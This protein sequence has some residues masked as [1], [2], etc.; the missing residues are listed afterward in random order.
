MAERAFREG[1]KAERAG[2]HLKAYFLYVQA[3]Q[4]DAKNPVYSG[5]MA[6]LAQSGALQPRTQAIRDPA[7]ETIGAQLEAEGL[8]PDEFLPAAAPPPRL[9]ASPEKRNFTI[10]GG[11]REMFEQ[12]A[13]AY[14]I[15]LLFEPD[16]KE[17]PPFTFA[18]AD[19]G[20]QEALRSL[21]AATD[22]FVVPLSASTALVA[23]DTVPNRTQLTPVA[24]I[25]VPIPERIS[26][27]E[28]Q[29]LSTAV[30][31]T[32]EIRRIS[33]DASRRV[34]YFRDSVSKVFAAREMFAS[35]SRARAQ[36]AVDVEFISVSKTS[37]LAYGL[38]LP[39]SA[40]II[41]F[42]TLSTNTAASIPAG[43]PGFAAIGGGKTL[44]GIGI[45]NSTALATLGRSAS[46]TLLESQ[47][48]AL[49]GQAVT[50]K[51]GDRYPITTATF[52]GVSGAPVAGGGTIPTIN[53]VD[54][55]LGLKV[56]PTVHD[57][58]EVTLDIEA[59]FKSIGAGGAN[60]I[61]AISNQEYQ[62]KVRLKEGEWAVVA[63]LMQLTNTNNLTGIA[64]LSNIPI[65]GN[66]FRSRTRE[67]DRNEILLVLKPRLIGA[68]AWDEVVAKPIWTGTETRPV[69]VF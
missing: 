36:I 13:A 52:S 39:T 11:A 14:G 44:F 37:S 15:R 67:D 9:A 19:A 25:A 59:E 30:Q 3:A 51:V 4:T 29:E 33:L 20:Y 1:Q 49:D 57:G 53:Y 42:G 48:V 68:P 61:P 46:S 8:I 23:R 43:S 50:F 2:D 66:L 55:G 34:V 63:G 45:G 62:G 32:L 38:S 24:A 27:Q 22:S 31:Q 35:L 40:S 21:E 28:A 58:G 12:V 5:K 17:P 16:Y 56:T 6:A 65:L 47:I 64:G 41:N 10:K 60:G 7:D 54:L 26:I 69:T 18:I